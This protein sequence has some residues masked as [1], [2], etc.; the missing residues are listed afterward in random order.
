M[1]LTIFGVTWSLWLT[2]RSLNVSA[3]IGV[4]MLAG[5]VVN[6]A[7]VL[8]DYIETLR[9]Y[10]MSRTE[11]VLHAGPTRLRPVLMTTLTTVLGMLPLALGIG[12][13]AEMQAPLAT[14]IIGGLSFSTLLTLIAIP[15]LYT[16]MDDFGV[17]LRRVFHKQ[18]AEVSYHS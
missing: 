13:G 14:V 16:V 10:G 6:N 5:I 9:R 17:W 8:V 12:D 3:L 11:A 2:G 18:P 15:V 7:I 4:I 1:P